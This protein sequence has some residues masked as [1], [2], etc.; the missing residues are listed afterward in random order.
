MRSVCIT[1]YQR[2][3]SERMQRILNV[4]RPYSANA[5]LTRSA[6]VSVRDFMYKNGRNRVC[7]HDLIA[8]RKHQN[9][10]LGQQQIAQLGVWLNCIHCYIINIFCKNWMPSKLIFDDPKYKI[11]DR[12]LN[13]KVTFSKYAHYQIEY[14]R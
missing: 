11:V 2:T 7:V 9:N 8:T 13:I 1:H 5:Q 6:L 10:M 12:L 3:C 4:R 14:Q